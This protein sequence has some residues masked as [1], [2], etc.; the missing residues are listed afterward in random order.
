MAI[1]P[2]FKRFADEDL[3]KSVSKPF[4]WHDLKT[5]FEEF[6]IQYLIRNSSIFLVTVQAI[7]L[8]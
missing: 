1:N 6:L 8:E 2:E 7:V 4:D 5:C 3:V